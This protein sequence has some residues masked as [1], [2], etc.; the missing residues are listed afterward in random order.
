MLT[1]LRSLLMHSLYRRFLLFGVILHGLT[2][3]LWVSLLILFSPVRVD[4]LLPYLLL[5]G[6]A[7]LL[8]ALLI[9]RFMRYLIHRLTNTIASVHEAGH[10]FNPPSPLPQELQPLSFELARCFQQIQLTESLQQRQ[11]ERLHYAILSSKSG[12]WEWDFVDDVAQIS[13]EMKALLGYQS[14]EL[15]SSM[16]AWRAQ[17]HSEDLN[18]VIAEFRQHIREPTP[19]FNSRYRARHR[20]GHFCWL[21][22]DG[23]ALRNQQGYARRIVGLCRDITEQQLAYQAL[24]SLANTFPQDN[25]FHDYCQ[26]LLQAITSALNTRYGLIALFTD[27]HYQALKPVVIYQNGHWININSSFSLEQTPYLATLNKGFLIVNENVLGH[28]PRLPLFPDLILQS[29]VGSLLISPQK[30]RILG[31]LAVLDSQALTINTLQRNLFSR[32]ARRLAF[33]LERLPS[34]LYNTVPDLITHHSTP[35]YHETTSQRLITE[36]MSASPQ[37][38]NGATLKVLVVDDSS[39]NRDMVVSMLKRLGC[40]CETA[41]NG[42]IALTKLQQQRYDLVLMDCEMPEMD[43]YTATRELRLYEKAHQL[44]H[45]PVLALTAHAFAEH[46]HAC[47]AAGMDDYLTKPLRIQVL[48]ETLSRWKTHMSETHHLS[49][50]LPNEA[51]ATAE[52]TE[53]P[54]LDQTVIKTLQVEMGMDVL[55]LLQQLTDSIAHQLNEFQALAVAAEFEQ[56]RRQAHRLKGESFQMGAMRIGE[57]CQALEAEAKAER[58][59]QVSPLLA[60]LTTALAD[61]QH[62][63]QQVALHD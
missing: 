29:Y 1:I 40:F 50:A 23:M 60:Q 27:T 55:P 63:T 34:Y 54:I 18:R 8:F 32:Y 48:R 17:I 9:S 16:P 25:A 19:S 61:L 41:S 56:L 10:T 44:S 42:Q 58:L 37:L 35:T 2:A 6:I 31:I 33:E 7:I 30:D 26:M 28:Y 5:V 52:T 14:H 57:L 49:P 46:R 11:Q 24:Q 12:L 22:M 21:Q 62:A 38:V 47:T 43:G 15:E 53:Y 36:T 51:T 39:I 13:A 59:D 3:V 20:D 4:V 45:T